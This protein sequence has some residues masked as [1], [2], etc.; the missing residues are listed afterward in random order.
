MKECVLGFGEKNTKPWF[1]N[2]Q[3]AGKYSKSFKTNALNIIFR[4]Q[5]RVQLSISST[6]SY[7]KKMIL[8]ESPPLSAWY[9]QIKRLSVDIKRVFDVQFAIQTRRSRLNT[10]S[11]QVHYHVLFIG[12][13]SGPSAQIVI[14]VCI[15]NVVLGWCYNI[16]CI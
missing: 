9:W 16:V 14:T 2:F 15:A 7:V 8:S 3:I 12:R 10:P 13:G 1:T 11:K 4:I 5:D 6:R